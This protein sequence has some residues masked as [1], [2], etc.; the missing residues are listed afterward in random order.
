VARAEDRPTR[1]R[2]GPLAADASEID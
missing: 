1:Y 2:Q